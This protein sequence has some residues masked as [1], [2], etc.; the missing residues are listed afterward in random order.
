VLTHPLGCSTIRSV[1]GSTD[2]ERERR[3]EGEGEERRGR[4]EGEGEVGWS[5]N[6]ARAGQPKRNEIS[7]IGFGMREIPSIYYICHYQS[8]H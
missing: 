1:R 3:G 7:H 8:S 5:I 6:R 2:K 4:G